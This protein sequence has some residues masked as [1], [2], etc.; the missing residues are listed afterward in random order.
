MIRKEVDRNLR[1]KRM[2]VLYVVLGI[3]TMTVGV[4]SSASAQDISALLRMTPAQRAQALR[5]LPPDQ[6]RAVMEMIQAQQG[7]SGADT[8]AV[9]TTTQR[10]EGL[11]IPAQTETVS[12]DTSFAEAN[13]LPEII[14]MAY[15]EPARQRILAMEEAI[16]LGRVP[17]VDARDALSGYV[18]PLDMISSHV[19]TGTPERYFL[20][21]GDE[22]LISY[23]GNNLQLTTQTLTVNAYG[24]VEA[25][26]IGKIVV[27][28]MTLNQFEDA[29]RE[30]YQRRNNPTDFEFIAT[31]T[32][33]KSIHIFIT[34]EA[35]RPGSY[36]VSAV[37]TLFNA[38]YACGGPSDHG[39]L[40]HIKLLR[41]GRSYSADFYDF[42]LKGSARGDHALQGGDIIH[43][44][45]AAHR[46]LVEGE[47]S[48]SGF[49]E[50][51]EKERL[52][53]LID[54]AGGIRPTGLTKNV[55]VETT[56]PGQQRI[57]RDI[58]MA[59]T[60]A[61]AG[62]RLMDGDRVLVRPLFPRITN[63][64][65]V[66][67][68]VQNP[69]AYELKPKMRIRHLVESA[70]PLENV[71][72]EKAVL[73]RF[74]FENE[75]YSRIEVNLRKLF[76]GDISENI[77]LQAWDSLRVY[78]RA[79]VDFT[80][81]KEVVV[82]GAVQRPGPYVRGENMRVADLVFQA[83]GLLPD[84]FHDQALI[85]R[86]DFR[87]GIQVLISINLDRALGGD[88][89]ENRIL[90]DSDSLRIF[91]LSEAV[92]TPAHEVT[93]TG[94]V[95]RPGTYIRADSMRV[96]DLIFEAGG[97]LPGYYQYAN[98][99]RARSEKETEI[100]SIDLE[101][102][103][104]GNQSQNFL[105]QDQ[106]ILNIKKRTDFYDM[107]HW[108][109]VSG[110]VNFPGPY[111]LKNK[112]VRLSEIIRLAGG[113]TFEAYPKGLVLRRR[114]E[115]LV[116]QDQ[117]ALLQSTNVSAAEETRIQYYQEEVRNRLA[118]GAMAKSETEAESGLP[119]MP[120]VTGS[121]ISGGE[122]EKTMAAGIVPS[123]AE[124]TG[125]TV[126]SIMDNISGD[127]SVGAVLREISSD[128]LMF[129]EM[130]RISVDIKD[131][132]E[133]NGKDVVVKP[134]DEI[135]VPEQ[136][137][138]VSVRGAV[139]NALTLNYVKGKNLKYYIKRAG[140][141]DQ[142]ADKDRVRIVRMDGAVWLA[143]DVNKIEQGDIIYV[144]TRVMSAEIRST[145]DKILDVVKY[146]L[147]TAASI[148]IFMV[149]IEKIS[150]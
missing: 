25:A 100:V 5:S 40:R 143:D 142:D 9:Q 65:V 27:R 95:Q 35:F 14:G 115:F 10:F 101:Q 140:G 124:G 60:R 24:E 126:Q 106:D 76:S 111:A 119:Q 149:L 123:I 31:L 17:A 62:L 117:E 16:R 103:L 88:H 3:V 29:A 56:Q 67:G 98:L 72:L 137:R 135:Y 136:P 90:M 28:G 66:E 2:S 109:T 112:N 54:L 49:Y 8:A 79:D 7:V 43:I 127:P 41:G 48:R 102:L 36:S 125:R 33:L 23:W 32:R 146:T 63:V 107:P 73:T 121:V 52:N 59:D 53:D 92:F 26:G 30:Q 82:T 128:D 116:Q 78:S 141:Y 21:P 133:G 6:Q 55:F 39:S 45:R 81:R 105:M 61:V 138:T 4:W 97:L 134:G 110:E 87:R 71:Y 19:Q 75:T 51:L 118:L 37:T 86:W 130:E 1:L 104:F 89:G 129:A 94:A 70:M 22:I 83:G 85:R 46:V 42:L 96:S 113:F 145:T 91:S 50:V 139:N 57:T 74:H 114:R 84:A 47:V 132:L 68:H 38:L 108:V 34:G 150:E 131:V 58:D 64:V 69:G 12:G 20:S 147:S 80:P 44:S 122:I 99:A 148:A 77:T 13:T 93:I 144:P 11:E 18:G 15:F 120:A